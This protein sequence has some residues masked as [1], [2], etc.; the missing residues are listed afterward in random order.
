MVSNYQ[1]VA[2]VIL[3]VS[4]ILS[5]GCAGTQD[6]HKVMSVGTEEEKLVITATNYDFDPAQIEVH[7]LRSVL[8][9]L[10]N[11]TDTEH[12]WT[13]K[14]PEGRVL[15]S[16]DMPPR[17]TQRVRVDFS[18]AGEHPFHCD[19]PFHPTLG[20]TGRVTVLEE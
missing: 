11:P 15:T 19:K 1:K 9:E 20:M 18:R 16:V 14:D 7:G 8:I 5:V 2:A 3:F 17:Q 13:I 12:N 4:W 10:E 6:T